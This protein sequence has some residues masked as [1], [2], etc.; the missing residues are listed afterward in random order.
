MSWR[1]T[2]GFTQWTPTLISTALWFD[3]AD[4]TTVFS[5]AGTTQ[6][7]AGSSTVQ[8]WNDKS[9]N[10]RHAT[11]ATSA[12]RPAYTANALNGKPVLTFD[13]APANPDFLSYA[14]GVE[15]RTIVAVTQTVTTSTFRWVLG[16]DKASG[17]GQVGAFYFGFSSP[18]RT[19]NFG[20]QTTADVS[21]GGDF[22]ASAGVVSSGSY[23]I[24]GGRHNDTSITAFLNGVSGTTDT[25]ASALRPVGAGAIGVSYYNGVITDGF[26]GTIAEIIV[27]ST[28][29][30]DST[31][32]KIE[33][34]LAWKWGLTANLPSNHP[35]KVN[36]PAP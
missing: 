4:N 9:G 18:T 28:A 35:F 12:R 19:A 20:R 8:Q 27:T 23:V 1:I 22:D 10:A 31:L 25:T 13:G 26:P 17:T 24:I 33:G 21:S 29:E 15:P 32:H 5:D 16:A 2:P 6:A 3:A 7:E 30:A 34:Y 14:S 36:P 11:Q